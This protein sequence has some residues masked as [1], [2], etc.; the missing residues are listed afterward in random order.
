MKIDTCLLPESPGVLTGAGE[1]ALQP[2]RG[3]K[4][5]SLSEGYKLSVQKAN[6]SLRGPGNKRRAVCL[7][8]VSSSMKQL[9][10]LNNDGSFMHQ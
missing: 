10:V 9:L 2:S 6:T 4:C 8:T 1:V 7:Y 5:V 3:D